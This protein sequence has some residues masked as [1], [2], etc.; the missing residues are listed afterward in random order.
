M[1]RY[2]YY[3][4]WPTERFVFVSNYIDHSCFSVFYLVQ[5]FADWKA[6]TEQKQAEKEK[7]EVI[8]HWNPTFSAALFSPSDCSIYPSGDSGEKNKY[9]T[10]LVFS[11]GFLSYGC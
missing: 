3:L 8:L 4:T 11:V 5:F 6:K 1:S 7:D 9:F 10:N 2:N